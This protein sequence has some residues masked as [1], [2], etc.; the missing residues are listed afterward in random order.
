M[1]AQDH[2]EG[3]TDDSST[4]LFDK[5]TEPTSCFSLNSRTI[6]SSSDMSASSTQCMGIQVSSSQ[7]T[8]IQSVKSFQSRSSDGVSHSVICAQHNRERKFVLCEELSTRT[9]RN[10]CLY[11]VHWISESWGKVHWQEVRLDSPHVLLSEHAIQFLC[12]GQ[13]TQSQAQAPD[14]Y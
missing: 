1:E 10:R 9:S 14:A 8:E 11:G 7:N 5:E 12:G 6:D 13:C 3:C 4:E 2:A